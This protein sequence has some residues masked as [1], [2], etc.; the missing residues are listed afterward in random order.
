M[1]LTK[2]STKASTTASTDFVA[3]SAHEPAMVAVGQGNLRIRGR[4]VRDIVENDPARISDGWC[5]RMLGQLVQLLELQHAIGMPHGSI[6][7]DTVV[8]SDDGDTMLLAPRSGG[9]P[10]IASDIQ[11]LAGMVHYAI[12][13]EQV[14]ARPLRGRHLK[15]FSK[16]LLAAVDRGMAPA[17][18]DRP[19]NFHEL[20]QLLGGADGRTGADANTATRWRLLYARMQDALRRAEILLQ[21]INRRDLAALLGIAVFVGAAVGL[22]LVADGDAPLR[23]VDRYEAPPSPIAA[24]APQPAPPASIAAATAPPAVPEQAVVSGSPRAAPPAATGT[25]LHASAPVRK[26]SNTRRA[27]SASVAVAHRRHAGPGPPRP[28]TGAAAPALPALPA[29]PAA[30]S[31]GPAQH[32]AENAVPAAAGGVLHLLIRPWGM[33]YVDGAARGASP[34]VKRIQLG[35]GPH[36]VLVSNP[37]AADRMVAVDASDGSVT[38][39]IDFGHEP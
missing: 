23:V 34:P 6:S 30:P 3:Q 24:T 31:V 37:H 32:R 18:A 16:S 27:R 7:A 9:P 13:R 22:T 39:A 29:A 14:P 15:G 17:P 21:A 10:D 12:T 1:A 19:Q 36:T 8:V 28:S 5:R 4:T 20:R 2:A 11:A 33:V 35:P 26:R 25:R 38:I